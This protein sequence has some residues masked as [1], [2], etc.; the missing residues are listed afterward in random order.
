M[1]VILHGW[2]HNGQLWQN[3]A[4]KLGSS[5]KSLDLPGF[6]SEPLVEDDW[7]VPQYAHWVERKIKKYKNVVLIGHSFGGRIAAEIASR[8]Q[9]YV[10]GLI[11]SGAPCI[12]RPSFQTLLRIKIY[13]MLRVFFTFLKKRIFLANKRACV[14]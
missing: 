4:N 14:N 9:I 5:A 1:I 2:G 3:L 7:G 13:K 12:Y 6:G 10:K 11:L 8:K